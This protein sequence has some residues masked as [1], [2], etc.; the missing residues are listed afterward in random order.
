MHQAAFCQAAFKGELMKS[1]MI[2]VSIS[3]MF[4]FSG[5]AQAWQTRKFPAQ[6]VKVVQI[7]GI[8]GKVNLKANKAATEFTMSFRFEGQNPS[9]DWN[10]TLRQESG[11]LILEIPGP[12]SR[13]DWHRM[14]SNGQAVLHINLEGPS[15]PAALF[16]W[17]GDLNVLDWQA[18]LKVTNQKGTVKIT[19]GEGEMRVSMVEGSLTVVKR[20]GNV[21]VDSYE[22]KLNLA[23]MEGDMRIQNFVGRTFIQENK[24]ELD[25]S[26]FKGVSKV[27]KGEGQVNFSNGRGSLTIDKF[28]GQIRGKSDEGKVRVVVKGEADVRVR[29]KD[30]AISVKAPGSGAYVNAGTKDGRMAVPNYLKSTRYPNL[31]VATG[32]MRGVREAE[33]IFAL[34]AVTLAFGSKSELHLLKSV[35]FSG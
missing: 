15:V 22:A 31:R 11:K 20:K 8:R 6:E 17:D 19:G 26:S 28:E 25:I 30:G 4:I 2:L 34:R 35:D 33:F 23:R 14:D 12:S 9:S 18:P 29:S 1:K 5:F 27:T 13:T 3:T 21:Q 10:P 32:R 16:W 24:G 7:S